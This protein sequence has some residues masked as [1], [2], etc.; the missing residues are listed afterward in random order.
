M[1]DFA[2]LKAALQ[3]GACATDMVIAGKES[4]WKVWHQWL[5]LGAVVLHILEP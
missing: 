5:A 3:P 1:S 2:Y 4:D